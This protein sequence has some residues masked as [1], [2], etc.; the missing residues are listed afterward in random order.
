M[1]LK[2]SVPLVVL[3]VVAVFTMSGLAAASP[4]TIADAY[5]KIHAALSSDTTDGVQAAAKTI[6]ADAKAMGPAGQKTAEV[7]ERMATAADL[8]AAR[9]VFGDL[10]DA[11]IELVGESVGDVKKA[12]CP[13]VKKFWLQKG[14]QIANP[15]YGSSM[16]RCGEFKK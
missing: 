7:A 3:T 1:N 12:Y 8:K 10:S 11:V 2:R 14:D 6:A 5:L 4:T 15:Y 16:L 9:A 13:M